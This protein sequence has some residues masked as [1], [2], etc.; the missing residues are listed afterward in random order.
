[1]VTGSRQAA[2]TRTSRDRDWMTNVVRMEIF[3]GGQYRR[4]GWASVRGPRPGK[5]RCRGP[6]ATCV[7]ISGDPD[8]TV[9]IGCGGT[10]VN[11]GRKEKLHFY[12]C[13]SGVSSLL[14][15]PAL[16]G[17]EATLLGVMTEAGRRALQ[18]DKDGRLLS[19]KHQGNGV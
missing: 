14:R 16:G 6:Q 8:L 18:N 13:P 15:C 3:P 7:S 12:G 19:S 2:I 4:Y 5:G 9:H 11:L 17:N 10:L 1:M